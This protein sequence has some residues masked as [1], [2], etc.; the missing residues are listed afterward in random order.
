MDS[1]GAR[2]NRR[3][4]TQPPDLEETNALPGA[5]GPEPEPARR[6]GWGLL[7]GILLVVAA[8][9]GAA[10]LYFAT[11]DR[12]NRN[13]GGT[14][15]TQTVTRPATTAAAPAAP[16]RVF[17]PD[18]T[19]L[20]QD[21]AVAHLAAA[22]LAPEIR[23]QS[24]AKPT[25]TV[26]GQKPKAGTRARRGSAV[27]LVVDGG[28]PAR[29]VPDVSGRTVADA[30]AL[31]RRAGFRPLTTEV[32]SDAAPGTV[33]SQAPAAGTKARKGA[34]IVLS[35]ARK[36]AGTATATTATRATTVTTVTTVTTAAPQAKPSPTVT[37]PDVTG[38]ELADAATTFGHAGVFPNVV[39]VPSDEPIGT[40]LEQ[41]KPAGTTVRRGTYVRLNVAEGPDPRPPAAIPSVRG[42][43]RRDAMRTLS[44]AGFEV[45]VLEQTVSSDRPDDTAIAQQPYAGTQIPRGSLVILIVGMHATR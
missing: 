31:L 37:V 5:G 42:K 23:H 6:L 45:K 41:A 21:E 20:A 13:D 18:V 14:T 15:E 26:V 44:A 28:A 22:H 12:G 27:V 32:T 1:D 43:P 16:G 40:V 8:A 30:G 4:S 19:G 38:R 36:A 29:A 17:V 35:I 24:T 10:A 7:I 3:V 25:G 2:N 39:Y 34:M 9:A 11:G 33:V